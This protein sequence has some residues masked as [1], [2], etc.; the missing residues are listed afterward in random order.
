VSYETFERSS[1]RVEDLALTVAPTGRIFLNAASG[2]VLEGAGV[3]A[4]K[5][6]WDKESC[7]IALQAARKGDKNAYSIAHGGDSRSS[8]VTA[9]A[10][11][12][13]IGWSSDRRQTVPAKWDAQQKMLEAELPPRFVTLR[14][15]KLAKR[16][17]IPSPPDPFSG[18]DNNRRVAERLA[19]ERSIAA[20]KTPSKLSGE[21]T[22]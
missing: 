2:R 22:G 12:H 3:R 4:V 7:R 16:D 21:G 15:D 9:K 18:N 10:F 5:I 6:L 20:S 11:L 17:Q 8:T 14:G 13:Y 19:R 1:V